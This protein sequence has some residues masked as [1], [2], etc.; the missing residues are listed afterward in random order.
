MKLNVNLL[1]IDPLML[2]I[3]AVFIGI[4]FGRIKIYKF[5]FGVAGTLFAGLLLGWVAIRHANT[6]Q[7][8]DTTF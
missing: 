6:S 8:G 5:S 4:L 1:L 7:K 2:M 3:L